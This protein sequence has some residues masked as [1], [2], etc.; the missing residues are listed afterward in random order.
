MGH[1]DGLH[2]PVCWEHY[3]SPRVVPLVLTLCGHSLC[4]GCTAVLVGMLQSSSAVL[5]CPLCRCDNHQITRNLALM[6][7]AD[8]QWTKPTNTEVIVISD[9]EETVE[10]VLAPPP[11]RRRIKRRERA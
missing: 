2:C 10:S 11:T 8:E 9:D 4:A 6:Q 5:V 1:Q 7:V 3:H